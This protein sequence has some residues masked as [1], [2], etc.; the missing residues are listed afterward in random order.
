MYVGV[1]GGGGGPQGGGGGGP[2]HCMSL[3]SN[4]SVAYLCCP[5]IIKLHVKLMKAMSHVTSFLPSMLDV[6]L[7]FV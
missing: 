2:H 3:L 6:T 4:L 5:V 7:P 1:G